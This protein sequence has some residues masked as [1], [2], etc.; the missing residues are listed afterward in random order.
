[1][2]DE[3][4]T[5]RPNENPLTLSTMQTIRGFDCTSRVHPQGDSRDALKTPGKAGREQRM[6]EPPEKGIANHLDPESCAG[7]GNSVGEALTG[8]HAGQTW[9]SEI[10]F[11]ACRPRMARGKGAA[12]KGGPYRDTNVGL[13]LSM[14]SPDMPAKKSRDRLDNGLLIDVPRYM[15]RRVAT[16]RWFL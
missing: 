13:E 12:R 14:V 4:H 5:V 11:P 15:G 6:Q 7:A 8:A 1:M 3:P 9:N 16:E 2:I 10:T